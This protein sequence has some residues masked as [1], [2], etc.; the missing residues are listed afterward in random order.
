MS[1]KLSHQAN[2]VGERSM[3]GVF[4][5]VAIA[6]QDEPVGQLATFDRMF[7]GIRGAL[8]GAIQSAINTAESHLNDDYA[9]RV[10]KAL[11]LV[12]YVKEFKASQRNLSVLMTERFGED[13]ATQRQKLQAAL[14]LLE[15]Q[16]YIQRNGELYEFLT[17]E[18]K[19]IEQEIK[20]TDIENS[21]VLKQLEELFFDGVIRQRKIRQDNGQDY[22]YT[23]KMDDRVLSRESELATGIRSPLT[24]LQVSKRRSTKPLSTS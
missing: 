11:F 24:S 21:D 12:K 23:R 5:E 9:V 15:Q 7:E 2:S 18:E 22:A 13:A 19:D 16:T 3:L 10:L 20:N 14:N 6:I 1:Q 17:N 4:R 8:K